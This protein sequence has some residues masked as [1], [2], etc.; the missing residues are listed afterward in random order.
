MLAF[1]DV[2]LPGEQEVPEDVLSQRDRLPDAMV[3]EAEA[4]IDDYSM[5]LAQARLMPNGQVD[6]KTGKPDTKMQ[7]RL[8]AMAGAQSEI[9]YAKAQLKEAETLRRRIESEAAL[10]AAEPDEADK[11]KRGRKADLIEA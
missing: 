6:E 1:P 2:F 4:R 3:R 11:P 10:A 8:D 5:M 7:K 9:D